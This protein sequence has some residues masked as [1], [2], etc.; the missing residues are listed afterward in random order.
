MEGHR[1]AWRGIEGHGGSEKEERRE[2]QKE[3]Y[4]RKEAVLCNVC[5]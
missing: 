3:I 1:G 5:Q 2:K 4:E